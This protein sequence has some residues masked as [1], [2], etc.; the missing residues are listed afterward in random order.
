VVGTRVGEEVK[1]GTE[2]G[3]G[4]ELIVVEAGDGR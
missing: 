1:V 4:F 2:G 3:S